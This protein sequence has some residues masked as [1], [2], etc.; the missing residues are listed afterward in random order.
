MTH[1]SHE[2]LLS[3]LQTEKKTRQL[4]LAVDELGEERGRLVL[5]RTPSI[6]EPMKVLVTPCSYSLVLI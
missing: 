4:N 2:K 6:T 3:C 1:F 5:A